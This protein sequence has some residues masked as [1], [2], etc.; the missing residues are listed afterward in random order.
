MRQRG[1]TEIRR[2]LVP[3]RGGPHAELA[4]TFADAIGTYH[5]ATVTVL[6]VV[7]P[8]ITSAV[9][10]QAERALAAFVK[11][12]VHGAAEPLVREAANVRTAI[13]REA[14]RADGDLSTAIANAS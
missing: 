4:L 12:H 7:P 11:Q 13:L 5:G 10:A 14:D 8:G 1:S 3:V 2:I 9:R 6:H